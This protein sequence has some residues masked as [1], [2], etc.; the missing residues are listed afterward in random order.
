MGVAVGVAV[1]VGKGEGV[2]WITAVVGTAR[3]TKDTPMG[4]VVVAD[5]IGVT[6]T[7][8]SPERQL[9]KTNNPINTK[10]QRLNRINNSR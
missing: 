2:V 9:I 7:A 8:A 6:V 10:I 3:V 4:S 1:A 5:E